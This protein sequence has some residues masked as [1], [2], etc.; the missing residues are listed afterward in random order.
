VVIAAPQKANGKPV[1]PEGVKIRNG[2]ARAFA[3]CLADKMAEAISFAEYKFGEAWN[4]IVRADA[5]PSQAMSDFS[6]HADKMRNVE[7][8]IESCWAVKFFNSL[9]IFRICD[10]L[11]AEY[12]IG[13]LLIL[14]TRQDPGLW[15]S[16]QSQHV[17][18]RIQWNEFICALNIRVRADGKVSRPIIWIPRVDPGVGPKGQKILP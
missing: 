4:K 5:R 11:K 2:S 18:M 13:T 8:S 17:R 16:W 3:R 1:M 12:H 9:Q 10:V 6:K 14:L 7:F 15:E